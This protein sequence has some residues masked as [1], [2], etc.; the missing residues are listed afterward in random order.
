MGSDPK[1]YRY[2]AYRTMDE[3]DVLAIIA[4]LRTLAPVAN[5]VPDHQLDFPLNL[6]LNSIPL[7]A[8][9]RTINRDDDSTELGRSSW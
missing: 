3:R 7:A 1:L 4:Y 5:D 8:E 6:I 2:D 9:P